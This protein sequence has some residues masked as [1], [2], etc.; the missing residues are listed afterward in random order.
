MMKHS[1]LTLAFTAFYTTASQAAIPDTERQALID[2]YNALDLKDNFYTSWVD[3][4]QFR[5]SGTEC[6]WA[7]VMCE[8]PFDGTLSDADYQALPNHVIGI[9]PKTQVKGALQDPLSSLDSPAVSSVTGPVGQHF[10]LPPSLTALTHL[11]YLILNDS[12]IG[13]VPDLSSLQQLE[14]LEMADCNL[15]GPIPN[16]LPALAH[17]R[18]LNLQGNALNGPIPAGLANLQLQ[19]LWL[20]QNRLT[21]DVPPELMSLASLNS[22]HLTINGLYAND[23][24]LATWLMQREPG[25]LV[26]TGIQFSAYQVQDAED[27]VLLPYDDHQDTNTGPDQSIRVQWSSTKTTYPAHLEFAS[28]ADGSLAVIPAQ[29]IFRMATLPNDPLLEPAGPQQYKISRLLPNT[30]YN[31]RIVTERD[32]ANPDALPADLRQ[33]QAQVQLISDGSRANIVAYTTGTATPATV[34]SVTPS[35]VSGG[36]GGGGGGSTSLFAAIGLVALCMVRKQTREHG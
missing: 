13:S 25:S 14:V 5:P 9:G 1:L 15:T 31:F 24:S 2:L 17:L 26:G 32:G 34:G 11:K 12:G 18:M 36:G 21:G 4:G 19:G 29:S 28:S 33:A 20:Q 27:L 6:H 23:D 30:H 10:T 22:V 7:N 3:Q 8:I 35:S 16:W